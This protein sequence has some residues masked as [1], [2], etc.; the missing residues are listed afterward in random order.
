M[1]TSSSLMGSGTGLSSPS[2]KGGVDGAGAVGDVNGMD[3]NSIGANVGGRALGNTS[4]SNVLKVT[5]MCKQR[6]S[7]SS[8]AKN[9]ILR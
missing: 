7:Q 5:T 2:G 1:G 9:N 6:E 8:S 4:E 3:V